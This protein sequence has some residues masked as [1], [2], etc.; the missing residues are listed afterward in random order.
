MALEDWETAS[1]GSAI[2]RPTAT[3]KINKRWYL[4]LFSSFL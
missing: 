4:S 3:R 1:G 2:D